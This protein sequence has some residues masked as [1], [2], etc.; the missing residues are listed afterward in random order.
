MNAGWG[1]QGGR[2]GRRKRGFPA[3]WAILAVIA[4]TVLSSVATAAAET[5]VMFDARIVGD[6]N[7]TR[8]IADLTRDTK[9]AVFTLADPYR[10]VVD[11]S[12]VTFRFDQDAAPDMRGLFAAFRY[13]FISPGKSRM[14]LDVSGPV[15]V[16][17]SFVVPPADAQPARLVIDIVPTDRESF[18][19]ANRAYRESLGV[20]SAAR[21]DRAL[22]TPQNGDLPTVVLDPGHGGIDTGAKGRGG[23]IEKHVTL[24]FAEI[25]GEKLKE[26]GHYNVLFTRT[27]DSFVA[28]GD[29]VAFAQDNNADLFVSIHAN[30]FRG[31]S[32]RGAIIYTAA[33]EASGKM[34][35]ELAELENQVDVLAGLDVAAEDTDEVRDILID[36]TRRETRNFG[37]VFARNLVKEM[38]STT[39]MFKVPHQQANFRVLEAP[40]VPSALIELGF[41]SNADDE[42]LLLSEDWRANT[43]T[44][45]VEAIDGFFETKIA[46]RGGQ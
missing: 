6:E 11:M 26:T 23:A 20:Q 35:A 7:R 28:L 17:K 32:I 31:R 44:S 5:P 13:G 33:D 4:A 38:K 3:F 24:E 16:D 25:L 36:L 21:R 18:L 42:K 41:V 40:D 46:Q 14:V 2:F 39:R 43:A 34:A 27:D 45:I 9:A 30:S 1:T 15:R 22:S 29:R 10:I 19:E 12:E 37:T 8:F